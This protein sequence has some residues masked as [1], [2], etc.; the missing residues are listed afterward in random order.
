MRSV[1]KSIA[2]VV[3]IPTLVAIVYFG[4]IASDIY[5]SETKFAIRSSDGS[6]P[7][8]GLAAILTS[9]GS[10]TGQES[11][12]VQ[13]YM[14]SATMLGQL[15][16]RIPLEEHYRS[17]DIDW[18]ARLKSAY[19]REELLDYMIDQLQVQHDTSSDVLTL[20]ARAFDPEMA[21]VLAEE[22]ILLS[23]DLV[24]R[25]S[26]RIEDDSLN[27]A[28]YEVELASNKV[29][30][31]SSRL[32]KFRVDNKSIDPAQEGSALLGVLAG[33]ETRLVETRTE[34]NEKQAYMRESAPE[35]I[36]LRN[37][38]NALEKQGRIERSRLI[39]G[40]SE[41]R[42]LSDVMEDYRPLVI[43]Q[44]LAQQQY[45]SAL[46]SL[47]LARAEVSRQKQYLITFIEP[48]L[49]DEAL[50]PRRINRILTVLTFSFLFYM[51]GGL[52]W[53]AL[54]DHIGR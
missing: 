26:T 13:D 6:S 47:E 15:L 21:K 42:E 17:S 36:A 25:M 10:G 3:G 22:V 43:E 50:E 53:S 23:E 35:I 1:I 41:S 39:D 27:R 46:T 33:I 38:L 37:R 4:F 7:I 30:D 20:K 14:H 40:D 11:S 45:A 5:V 44:E 52:M 29:T 2:V 54:R 12:V 18:L 19:T 51:I 31:V 34:L 32:S 28:R 48:N 24:N 9:S 16:K 49:P 8:T